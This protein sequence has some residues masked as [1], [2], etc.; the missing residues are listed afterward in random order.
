MPQQNSIQTNIP[1]ANKLDIK[2]FLNHKIPVMNRNSEFRTQIDALNPEINSG[3]LSS[4]KINVKK[5]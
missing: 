3:L 5:K 4:L 1:K 2:D